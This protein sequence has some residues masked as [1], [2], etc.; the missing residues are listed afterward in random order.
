MCKQRRAL[1]VALTGT[2]PHSDESKF[3]FEVNLKWDVSLA[4]QSLEELLEV[5]YVSRMCHCTHA[6]DS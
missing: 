2:A 6:S 4:S 5:T 3:G 1:Q